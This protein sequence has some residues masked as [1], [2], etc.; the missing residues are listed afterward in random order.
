MRADLYALGIILSESITGAIPFDG[1]TVAELA[2]RVPGANLAELADALLSSSAFPDVAAT[3]RDLGL[4]VTG[5]RVALVPASL[6]AV[7][8]AIMAKPAPPAPAATPAGR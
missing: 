1:P 5:D 4:A 6:A 2:R 8:D 7:R 3:Y